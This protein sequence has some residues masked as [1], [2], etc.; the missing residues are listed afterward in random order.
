MIL[1]N[2][3]SHGKIIKIEINGLIANYRALSK[4]LNPKIE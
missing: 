2:N 1:E 3:D 4:E